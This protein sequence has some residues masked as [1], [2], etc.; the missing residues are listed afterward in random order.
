MRLAKRVVRV[1]VQAAVG[2]REDGHKVLLALQ[3][4]A[5]ESTASWKA[6]VE[7]LGRRGLRVPR[8]AI[9]DGNPGL[10]RAVRDTWPGTTIQRCTQHK[11]ANLLAKAPRHAH[12]ERKRDYHAIVYAGDLAAAQRA[13]EAFARKGSKRI[14]EVVRSLEEAGDELLS[15]YRFPRSPWR[16]LRTTNPLERLNGEFRRRTKTQASFRHEAAA[17]VLWFGLVALGQIRL[18]RV[19]G[20]RDLPRLTENLPQA[21]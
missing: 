15:F 21:A 13:W 3:I 12:G 19:D 14:P 16:C 4:V 11:L 1:P 5:S 8:L 2:V 7:D 9:L 17:L 6:L 18:R 20:W 10:V